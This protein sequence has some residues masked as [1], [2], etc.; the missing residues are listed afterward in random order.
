MYRRCRFR[1][2]A[3]LRQSFAER[4]WFALFRPTTWISVFLSLHIVSFTAVSALGSEQKLFN[5]LFRNYNKK[6]RPVK[7]FSRPIWV[8]FDMALNQI[9]DMDERNQVL[10]TN[11]WT[12]ETWMDEMMR[13]N[14]LE[15]DGIDQIRIPSSDLWMPD[16][17]LYNNAES[18]NYAKENESSA[19]CVVNSTGGVFYKSKPTILKSTCQVYVKYFPFDVQMCKMKFGSWAYDS[20][21]V[22]MIQVRATPDLQYFIHNEQWNLEFAKA[23]RHITFYE[24]CPERYPDISFYVCIR[25]KPLYYI[26][27]LIIP[28]VLLCALS[29]LGFFMPYNVGVVKAS[30]SVTLILS[31]TV[32]LLLV[33]EMMPR[34]SKEIPLIG[35]YYLAA[36]SLISVSTAMNIAVLNVNVCKREVPQWIKVAVM[37]YLA[38]AVCMRG[39]TCA[40]E[41]IRPPS[42]QI[43]GF[44]RARSLDNP[45]EIHTPRDTCQP[46]IRSSSCKHATFHSYHENLTEEVDWQFSKVEGSV[47]EIFKHLKTVQRKNDRKSALRDEWMKVATILDKTLMFLF[48]TATVVTSM[49]LL[50]QNPGDAK[51]L[52][53]RMIHEDESFYGNYTET[54]TI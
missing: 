49:A 35:Q 34:T 54:Q 9:A 5:D 52:C 41:S 25:R 37:K 50:L 6:V 8:T 32:F 38:A 12:T 45:Y 23:R 2:Q 14:P 39:S 10:K 51:N 42:A 24:C 44:R 20:Q 15:Y 26:Y 43:V 17:T 18:I 46:T 11:I 36:M 3:V 21:Q 31:L 53:D 4:T 22:N 47:S 29:F 48:V 28:C 1:H 13:W 33:A 19:N 7:N 30:L 40:R 16:I 27:N